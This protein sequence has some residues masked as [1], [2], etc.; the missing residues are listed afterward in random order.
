MERVRWVVREGGLAREVTLVFPW[1]SEMI[2]LL[3]IAK[4]LTGSGCGIGGVFW[5]GGIEKRGNPT[6]Q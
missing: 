3:D 1:T 2:P 6:W 5:F 4:Q